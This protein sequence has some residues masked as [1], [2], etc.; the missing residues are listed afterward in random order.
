MSHDLGADPAAFSR[1]FAYGSIVL[2]NG[3]HVRMT[4][5]SDNAAGE[6]PESLY[7]GSLTVPA[8]T[9]LDLNG[10]RVYAKLARISGNVVGGS[11]ERVPDS[12]PIAFGSPTLGSIAESGELDEWTFFGRAGQSITAILNPGNDDT[13]LAVAPYLGYGELQLKDAAG[14]V[15]AEGGSASHGAVVT[16]AD[17]SLPSDG[18][19]RL[20]VR[21]PSENSN[22]T[23]NYA[24]TIWNV[25][26][27]VA[28]VVFNQHVVGNIEAP[29]SVDRWTFSAVAGQQIRLDLIDESYSGIV[30]ELAGPDGWT[31][32]SDLSGDSDL[33]T[34]PASGAYVLTAYDESGHY[35]ENYAFRLLETQQ[36][37]LALDV[38]HEG[39]LAGSGQAQLFRVTVL[40]TKPML[41]ALDDASSE[42]HNELYVRYGAPPTRGHF[43]YRSSTP[44]AAD[45][46]ILVAPATVGEWYVLVYASHVPTSGSYTL[47]ASVSDLFLQSVTP[48]HHSTLADAVLTLTGAGFNS[49]TAVELFDGDGVAYQPQTIEVDSF[50]QLTTTFAAGTVPVGHYGVRVTQGSQSEEIADA[51]QMVAGAQPRLETNLVVPRFVGYHATAVIYVNYAN[52][53]DAAM[54]APL[55][56]L[57][58]EQN[59]IHGAFLTLDKSRVYQGLWTATMPEGFANY[60]QLLGSGATPGVLQPGESV[61]VPVYYVGWQQPWDFSYPRVNYNL[62]VLDAD[63]TDVFDWEAVKDDMRPANLTMEQWEPVFSNLVSEAGDT[64]G[65]YVRMLDENAAYLARL[66]QQVNDIRDLLAFEALQAS[67]F[68]D[69]G[70]LASA[71]DAF[72]QAPGLSMSFERS[73][74]S[75]IPS[76]LRL[77]RLGWGWSDNWEYQLSV[78][79]DVPGQTNQSGTVIITGPGGEQRVFQ[80]DARKASYFS[81]PGDNATLTAVAG[82]SFMLE[83]TYGVVYAFR[84]DGKLDYVQD[85]HGNRITCVF[86]ADQLI[87]L[88]H[89]AGPFLSFSYTTGGRVEQIT[90]SVGRTT[91]FSYDA[92][93]EHLA[94]ATDYHELTITYDYYLGEGSAREHALKS[95]AKPGGSGFEITYD[96]LGRLTSKTGGCDGGGAATYSY[97]PAGEVTVTD[98]LSNTRQYFFDHRGRLLKTIDSLGNVAT[99][100]DDDDGRMRRTTDGTGRT[101]THT[102]D[103]LGNVASITD[104]MGHTTTYT[105]DGRSGRLT[106]FTDANGNVTRYAYDSVGNLLSITNAAGLSQSWTYD[107]RG[108]RTSWQNYRG[109]TISYTVDA[110]GR[111]TERLY[112]DGS[113]VTFTYDTRGNV[114]NYADATGTTA[115]EY[116]IFDRLEKITYPGDQWLAYT[117]DTAGRRATMEDQLGHRTVYHYNAHGDI[118]YLTDETGAEIVRYTYDAAGRLALKTLGNGVYTAYAYSPAGQLMELA[119]FQEDGAVLSEF[120]YT[121]NSHGERATMTTTYGEGDARQAGE[122]QYDY[123]DTGQLVGW[124]APDGRY[125]EYNYDGLGNRLSVQDAGVTTDYALNSRNQYTQVGDTTFEYD[126]DGNLIK[127]ITPGGTIVY[128]WSADNRLMSVSSPGQDIQY[129]YDAFGNRT[130]TRVNGEVTEFLVDPSGLGNVVSESYS[131]GDV[132]WYDHDSGLVSRKTASGEREYFTFDALG[133]TSELTYES[134]TRGRQTCSFLV[135]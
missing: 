65:D 58:V 62:T 73:F 119:N 23:G 38:I 8:D 94:S 19:Y 128:A 82:G 126:A 122:W 13:S 51:I 21:A 35:G 53:G 95:V 116:D 108:H 64:W 99:R 114:T 78:A 92:S 1:N 97:G 61:S 112:P 133:N 55:L 63:N 123:D 52:T 5:Q 90:D 26:A 31:G 120:A 109:D 40:E 36:T 85:T 49:T 48:D 67:G 93:G 28:P 37:T 75:D 4:D 33:I 79:H 110:M 70:T 106:S 80:P 45:Q 69:A 104:E 124:T 102:F 131:D 34:L 87:R 96:E 98:A 135:N 130:Q 29:F 132:Y 50:T 103:D 105:Y 2:E 56:E 20:Q 100:M 25:T 117:Y 6:E 66:G 16:L 76:R 9:T 107:N 3:A 101:T 30:F 111:V 125:V 18:I 121:Y 113:L 68:V 115:M 81:Q 17:V 27:D 59:G 118:E 42:N 44:A 127:E 57:H 43:D 129:T 91:M 11:V 24:I 47:L 32:F 72:A 22:R 15:L 88:E 54:P 77:G 39:T 10:L 12:G 7:V 86:T 14:T 83:E 46:E 84:S 134:G 41:I 74:D 89:N 60:I 71:T